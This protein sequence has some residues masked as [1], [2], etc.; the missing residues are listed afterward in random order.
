MPAVAEYP[1][2]FSTSPGVTGPFWEDFHYEGPEFK[3]NIGPK[4]E[5]GASDR[6]IEGSTNP[7]NVTQ[8]WTINY[9]ERRANLAVLDDHFNSACGQAYA[10]NFYDHRAGMLW[11]N[12]YYQEYKRSKGRKASHGK[13]KVVIIREPS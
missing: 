10:F 4:Y 8:K 7:A 2:P 6:N 3:V 5:D 11:T 12:C 1:N 13:R 9:D